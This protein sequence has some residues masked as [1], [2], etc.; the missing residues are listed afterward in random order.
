MCAAGGSSDWHKA[1]PASAP[2]CHCAWCATAAALPLSHPPHLH[3]SADALLAATLRLLHLHLLLLAAHPPTAL[4]PPAPPEAPATKTAPVPGRHCS[5]G[6]SG[7]G[8]S[9]SAGTSGGESS[10]AAKV[11]TL[12]KRGGPG[13]IL[14]MPMLPRLPQAQ[15]Y[16]HGWLH[17]QAQA[18]AQHSP[19]QPADAR[20]ITISA[21]TLTTPQPCP[22]CV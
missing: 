9:S 12:V 20:Q 1:R 13:S 21:N 10:S 15:S 2:A 18:Q 7:A 22:T 17:S 5:S 14:H 11:F 6:G 19:D 4:T 3:Q 8:S 16:Q